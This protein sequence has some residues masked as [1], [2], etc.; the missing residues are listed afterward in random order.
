[1]GEKVM[2]AIWRAPTDNDGLKLMAERRKA[3]TRWL[4]LPDGTVMLWLK[5]R[6]TPIVCR[7]VKA[8]L[9]RLPN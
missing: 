6:E 3:L 1:M 7:P 2:L 9:R 8:R 5:G 4:E